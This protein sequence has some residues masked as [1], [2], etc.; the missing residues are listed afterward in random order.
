MIRCLLFYSP[1]GQTQLVQRATSGVSV[2]SS[3]SRASKAFS[4][5]TGEDPSEYSFWSVTGN[6]DQDFTTS[7]KVK[8]LVLPRPSG[9]SKDAF[10]VKQ[11]LV[12][13]HQ[14]SV[15]VMKTAKEELEGL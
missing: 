4:A 2:A 5:T 3:M 14:D 13:K 1:I 11:K 10:L 6:H 12:M 15:L 8:N 9:R 7:R